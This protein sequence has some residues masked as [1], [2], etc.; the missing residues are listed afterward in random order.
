MRLDLGK[1]KLEV[2]HRSADLAVLYIA[3]LVGADS[4]LHRHT[5]ERET[6]Y[7]LSG[8]LEFLLEKELITAK[9]G[10]TVS[11][12]PNSTHRFCNKGSETASALLLLNPSH[13]VDYFIELKQLFDQQAARSELERLNQKFGLEFF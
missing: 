12:A 3:L 8:E 7:I 1:I 11:I 5:F 4:G 10:T 13:L 6:F 2:R 9:A